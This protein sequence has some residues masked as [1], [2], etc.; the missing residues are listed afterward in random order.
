M[1]GGK[2]NQPPVTTTNPTV[3]SRDTII[4]ISHRFN[5]LV[6]FAATSA[7]VQTPCNIKNNVTSPVGGSRLVNYT[8]DVERGQ[9]SQELGLLGLHFPFGDASHRNVDGLSE[10]SGDHEVPPATPEVLKRGG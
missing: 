8:R 7:A 3:S 5:K 2:N 9:N 4:L 6:L 1:K 10:D